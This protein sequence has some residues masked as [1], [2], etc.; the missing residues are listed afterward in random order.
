MR[1]TRILSAAFMAAALVGCT[2]EE[3]FDNLQEGRMEFTGAF[4][5][6]A[7]RVTMDN[8]YM[9]NWENEDMVSI[10]PGITVNNSYKVSGITNGKASFTFVDY[11]EPADGNYGK[12]EG[13]VNY[14][15]YPYAD[16]NSITANGS[17]TAQV[18]SEFAYDGMANSIKTALMAAKSADENLSFKNV[19]GIL[20]LRLNADQPLNY[21]AV[22]S[23]RIASASHTLS[24]A[25]TITF[26]EEGL[27]VATMA[28]GG[29]ELTVN[30]S[31]ELQKP[32]QNA[33]KGGYS[34][35]YIPVIPVSF[36]ANDVTM[37]IDW[38]DEELEDYVKVASIPFSI[39]RRKIYTLYHTIGANND[40]DGGLEGSEE[41][42][43]GETVTYPELV[44]DEETG[45][46]YYS[47][48]K[49]SDLAGLAA[50]VNGTAE[51]SSRAVAGEYNIKL[52]GN[53][54]LGGFNWTP[55]GTESNNFKG[56][57]DGKGYT[58]K[59][60][61]IVE[62]EAKEGKA[63]I[64]FFGYASNVTIKNVT[65]ENVN[66]NIPCLDIDHSQGHIGAVTGSLEGTSTIEDVTVKGDIKIEATFDANG[67]SRVAVVAGG[68]IDGNVT[69]KNVHVQAN[70]GSYLKANNN[71]G[72]LAGQ[73]QVKNV[74]ENC[75]S[76]I[77]VTAKKFYAGGIIG[78]AAGNSTFTNC[79]TT[80]NITVTGGR[81]GRHNDEYRVGGIAGGWA[82]NV[83]TP[84]VLTN[85]SYKGKIS[86][87]NSDGSIAEPLDYAGYVGRG[88]T[89][90]NRAGSKVVIDGVYYIQKYNDKYGEYDV[91]A[92]GTIAEFAGVKG[93][94]YEITDEAFKV[95]SVEECVLAEK[96]PGYANTW[97]ESL[98]EGWTLTTID[99]LDVIHNV[100]L[101]LN[102]FLKADDANNA[103]FEED[104]YIDDAQTLYAIYI[105]STV[106]EGSDPLGDEYFANRVFL[107]R[108]NKRGYW[109]VPRSTVDTINPNA[110]LR[111]KDTNYLARAVYTVAK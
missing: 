59:N 60:L 82:D 14:A 56:T 73:L 32:L 10:F 50:W 88:Y 42:W 37:T 92:V 17:I 43:D 85:C 91:Y 13:K 55:I 102:G 103:L 63:Y 104:D 93:I 33:A 30:L 54:D 44:T 62:E 66:L 28:E 11:I 1:T 61:S 83:T 69:M 48:S 89:L 76:N 58:I 100:R 96:T 41:V 9:M 45:E 24:G 65:F 111:A 87:T 16:A 15:L 105:S 70:D 108:F 72:A 84:C 8:E 78:L 68:N 18:P 98:G 53:I 95:V 23:I 31:E 81:E 67:A 109:D 27:P 2:Q 20:R 64:G 46:E 97:A 36:A 110:P 26:N 40:F 79:H 22:K 6:M 75:S 52:A 34:E 25:V 5:Q 29:K 35:Y 74:F 47:V 86:G 107:K 71:V 3:H 51:G 90:T 49:P 99:D 77:D 19:Q 80:G 4:E 101:A 106:A 94:I 57:F 39:E 7:S 38:V 21:G 12:T